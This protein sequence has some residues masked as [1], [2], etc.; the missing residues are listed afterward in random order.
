MC[1]KFI[2]FFFQE[3]EELTDLDKLYLALAEVNAEFHFNALY[4]S[5]GITSL[6][7]LEGYNANPADRDILS[8]SEMDSIKERIHNKHFDFE[9]LAQVTVLRLSCII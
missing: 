2:Y 3:V 7:A 8:P 1:S 9:N 6:S 4:Y 5:L